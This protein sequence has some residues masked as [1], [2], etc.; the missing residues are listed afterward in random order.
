[1]GT[2]RECR[3]KGI[4]IFSEKPSRLL[5]TVAK[6]AG[7]NQKT[8]SQIMLKQYKESLNIDRKHESGRKKDLPTKTK[9][10]K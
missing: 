9:Q 5:K 7:V 3:K 2:Q 4:E 6:L 10:V 1:M 8:V